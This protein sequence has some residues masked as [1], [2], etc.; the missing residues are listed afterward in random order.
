MDHHCPWVGTCIGKRNYKQFYL[1]LFSLL[2][3]LAILF[4]M[5][6]MIMS[7]NNADLGSALRRYPFSI[8]LAILCVP[9]FVFVAIMLLFHS[10]LILKN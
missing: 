4:G 6:V 2:V 10:Y 9:A 8:V 1:F 5:C 3:E 7:G